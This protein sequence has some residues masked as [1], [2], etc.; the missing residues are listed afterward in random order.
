MVVEVQGES[1]Q[2]LLVSQRSLKEESPGIVDWKKN[3]T[4]EIVVFREVIET[5]IVN[6][7]LSTL[8]VNINHCLDSHAILCPQSGIP[9]GSRAGI[10]TFGLDLRSN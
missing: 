6:S 8:R 7:Q 4:K 9:N 2:I 3:L 10:F 5:W 1:I